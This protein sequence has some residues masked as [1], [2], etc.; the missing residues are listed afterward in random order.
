MAVHRSV[1]PKLYVPVSVLG[2]LAQCGSLCPM[3][4][5]V[6]LS[7]GGDPCVHSTPTTTRTTTHTPQSTPVRVLGD[8]PVSCLI[9]ATVLL[10]LL[11][12]AVLAAIFA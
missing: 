12:T 9:L 7:V 4:T 3:H 1:Y 6:F 8:P 5:I 2:V 11:A 10:L